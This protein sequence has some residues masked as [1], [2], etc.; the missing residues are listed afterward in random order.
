MAARYGTENRLQWTDFFKAVPGRLAQPRPV[1]REKKWGELCQCHLYGITWSKT[2]SG[3][4]S[5]P[6]LPWLVGA[7]VNRRLEP[8]DA[9]ETQ[10]R[11]E[12][13]GQPELFKGFAECWRWA[14]GRCKNHCSN[15]CRTKS[16][17]CW[18]KKTKKRW[19]IPRQDHPGEHAS[20]WDSHRSGR[21]G[22]K[23]KG[24]YRQKTKIFFLDAGMTQLFADGLA[25]TLPLE[26][27]DCR[28]VGGKSFGEAANTSTTDACWF[29]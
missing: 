15:S 1:L 16:L 3:Y 17:K 5:I 26:D 23:P 21:D 24:N 19:D 25:V 28:T 9:S 22:R 29:E 8:C 27:D 20:E 7:S 12:P 14:G 18:G 11:N 2:G 10:K 6:S 13:T 4:I